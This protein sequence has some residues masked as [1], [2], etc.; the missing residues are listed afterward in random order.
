MKLSFKNINIEI[1]FQTL[2]I[3]VLIVLL[4]LQRSCSSTP[5]EDP[6]VITKIETKYDTVTINTTSYIPKWK[7]KVITK[8]DT[9]SLPIDTSLILKDYYAKYHY[10]DTLKIDSIGYAVINDTITQN[11]ILGRDIKTNLLIPTKTITE[12]IYLNKRELYWGVG[13]GGNTNQINYLGGE[14]I[15]R[16]KN[17]QAYGFGLGINQDFQP[18]ITG[19]M[20]WKIGR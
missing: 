9:F 20:Y 3:V 14:L 1:S 15:Y 19:R 18:I 5:K 12:T 13:L 16:N 7:T 2:I 17:K 10:S 11:K 8:I 6:Q 4:L